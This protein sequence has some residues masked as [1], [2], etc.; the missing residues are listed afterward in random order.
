VARAATWAVLAA[1]AALVV[2]AAVDA[3]TRDQDRQSRPAPT[4]RSPTRRATIPAAASLADDMRA[5]G[6]RGTL[7]FEDSSCRLRALKLPELAQATVRAMPIC[8]FPLAPARAP[9]GCRI[10]LVDALATTLGSLS[11]LASSCAPWLY[12]ALRAALADRC[13][14][15][16]VAE[17]TWRA[18]AQVAAIAFCRL[19]DGSRRDYLALFRNHR[20]A[21]PVSGP[22]QRLRELRMSPRGRY[23]SAL[24]GRARPLVLD[25]GRPVHLP[26][27]F[28]ATRAV[29]WSPD[30]RWL[31]VG[32]KR[33][34]Y[35]FLS[36]GRRARLHYLP[37]DAFDLAWRKRS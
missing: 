30:E 7:V 21:A 37:V 10:A 12:D 33:G 27:A 29:A 5:A 22:H 6:A 2:T 1:A 26:A 9:A 16:G 19:R 31:A 24:V 32:T 13:R 17:V 14:K 15:T 11:A 35:V 36:R 28:P 23:V 18:P 3:L 25:R 4:R 8:G 20:L 34:V